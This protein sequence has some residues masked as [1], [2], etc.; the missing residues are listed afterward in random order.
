M[1]LEGRDGGVVADGVTNLVQ[2][3]RSK[4][5]PKLTTRL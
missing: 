3:Y 4:L 1:T 2:K 5:L